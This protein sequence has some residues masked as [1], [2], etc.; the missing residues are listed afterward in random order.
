MK[1]TKKIKKSCWSSDSL[2]RVAG[3]IGV[4]V[5]S[6]ECTTKQTRISFARMLI[7]VNVTKELP[8]AIMVQDPLK[9]KLI[10]G[11]N[12]IGNQSFVSSTRSW[13]IGAM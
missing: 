11:C 10:N 12:T 7:E 3:A 1:K 9:K 5:Y 4:P 8:E 2:R 6:N 13:V